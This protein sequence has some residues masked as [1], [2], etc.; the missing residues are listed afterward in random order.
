VLRRAT[1]TVLTEDPAGS[2]RF[3]EGFLGFRVAMEEDGLL[4]FVSPDVPSTQVIVAWETPTAQ[5]YAV[6]ETTMSVEVSDAAAAYEEAVRLGLEIVRPLADE[7]WGIR[8]FFVREASGAVVN[9]ASHI[10]DG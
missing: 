7:P 3:Y 2:R 8:R 1:P 6:R 10:A 9:V 5:D 4:M